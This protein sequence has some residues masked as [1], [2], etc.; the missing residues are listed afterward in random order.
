MNMINIMNIIKRTVDFSPGRFPT[1]GAFKYLR[2]CRLIHLQVCTP[3]S[4]IVYSYV[5]A[6]HSNANVHACFQCMCDVLGNEEV[7]KTWNEMV[8]FTSLFLDH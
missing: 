8:K 6:E 5:M 4:R 1:I 2:N 7:S 3:T